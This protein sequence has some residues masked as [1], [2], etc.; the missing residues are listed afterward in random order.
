MSVGEALRRPEL[1]DGALW[2][3]AA[4]APVA[5]AALAATIGG[6]RPRR[7]PVAGLVVVAGSTAA[8]ARQGEALAVPLL[9]GVILLGLAGL[10][11]LHWRVPALAPGAL[12]LA[13]E[14]PSSLPTWAGGL[15]AAGC[16]VAGAFGPLVDSRH[17]PGVGPALL[18]G[19][20][21]GA[22]AC[23]PDVEQ[24]GVVAG[25]AGAIALV[26]LVVPMSLGASGT[27]AASGLLLWAAASG[28]IGRPASLIGAAASLGLLVVGVVGL[29]RAPTLRAGAA[30]VAGQAALIAVTSRVA[31]LRPSGTMAAGIASGALLL[32][33]VTAALLVSRTRGQPTARS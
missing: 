13:S 24:A 20:A 30:I 6:H 2:G 25:A 23:V 21:L 28:A 17:H 15:V 31:G 26:A 11:P 7:W 32:A 9:A 14:I 27:A 5:L 4:A 1:R 16:V 29:P 18:A 8:F 3:A 10:V 33:S 12:L 22:W 19:A